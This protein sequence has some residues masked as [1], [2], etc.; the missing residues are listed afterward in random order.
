MTG[1]HRAK[2]LIAASACA[3]FSYGFAPAAA[4]AAEDNTPNFAEDKLSGDWGGLRTGL[5]KSGYDV[6]VDYTADFWRNLSGG[7]S[8][9]N[10]VNDNLKLVVD[11]DGE[12]AFGSQGTSAHF[13]VLNNFGG[14][15]NDL[16]GSNGGIDNME[17]PEQAFKLF[18]AWVQQNFWDDKVSILAGLHDLNTEF[19]VTDT[20][21][22]FINPTYGIGTEM[23]ATGD[24]GPSV[25][26]YSSLGARI[27]VAPT[28][29]TYVMGAIYDGVPGD[30]NRP[31]GTH[32]RFNDKDGAL[33]VVEAGLQD[34]SIGHYGVGMWNYTAKRPDLVVAG[35]MANSRGVYFL[36]DHSFYQNDAQDISAF[37]RLGLT[38]GNVEQFKSNT[39]LGLVASGFV[40][41]RP[42][43]K[44]GFAV[45]RN[46]NSSKFKEANAGVDSN[47]TQW[48]LTY[49]DTVLPSV[50]IQPDL[51]YTV[52]PGTDPALDNAW[53]AGLRVAVNF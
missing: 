40:P 52:N 29:N 15:I 16:V 11:V 35:K 33:N 4:Q 24:N 10:R 36:A 46:A 18:E 9:G 21:G 44:I 39:S 31:R 42:D 22:L 12:K 34:D 49:S 8:K 14:R 13:F 30:P 5:Y 45:T 51:Q 50:T 23:A 53:T 7:V 48:E 2:L 19:Y 20:S 43:G 26:P 27:K 17:V 47:E 3:L 32:V 6:S 28:E 25:F 41:G 37:F 38:D 1:F